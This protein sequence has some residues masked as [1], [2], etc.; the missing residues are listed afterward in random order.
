[1]PSERT[2]GLRHPDEQA[3]AFNA[4]AIQS[5]SIDLFAWI[6]CPNPMLANPSKAL[7]IRV[8]HI[9]GDAV[10]LEA[11]SSSGLSEGLRLTVRR[12][13]PST[14]GADPAIVAEIEIES[15]AETSAAGRILSS[16]Q[17]IEPGDVAFLSEEGL[18]Q[19]QSDMH[20]RQVKKY[21]QVVNFTEGTPPEQ[22]IRESIPKPP[23]P[24]VNRIRGLI[25]VDYNGLQQPE[26]GT[27]SQFGF[28]LR[29]DATRL[30]G[31]Y[32]TVSGYHRGKIQ[33]RHD[34]GRQETLTDLIN[35]TYHLSVKYDNPGSRWVAGGGRLYVPWASSLS[36][37]DGFYLGRRVGKETVGIFG[38]TTPD[39]S[40]W[41]YDPNR[42]M[43]GAFVNFE[44]GGFESFRFT[45]TS[46]IALSWSH[47]D[48]DRQFG[49]FENGIFYKQYVSVYSTV[50]ADLLTDSNGS[51]KRELTLSRNYLTIRVQPHKVISFDI[52]ESYFRN[53]PTFDPQLIGTGLL[54]KFLFQG[55]SGGFRLTLPYRLEF[56]ANTGRSSRTNDQK[57]SWNYLA[58]AAASNILNSGVRAEY[59]YSR[60]DSSFGRGTYQ[61]VLAA[62]EIGEG[63]RFQV[64]AGRQAMESTFTA[65]NRAHF[66]N[67][68]MDWYF[69]ARYLLGFGATVYRGQTQHYNQYFINLGYRFDSRNRKKE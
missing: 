62:R 5:A 47:W 29:A 52:N 22:E 14:D 20:A 8:K 35:R 2:R 56:Y 57:P 60:F 41:N 13:K 3:K 33:S 48:P 58:G 19:V 27:R 69:G 39:P 30:G 67:G 59:R 61:S 23:L 15:V 42:L 4:G 34:P 31:T 54:D 63:F 24:E 36:T 28:V 68:N 43:T 12:G 38:G 55:L 10:Y 53:A 25:G 46:G 21:A 18:R 7:E 16:Q 26:S 37:I 11:G 40:S 17:K 49:F 66:I 65:Q 64:Q 6:I 50:E 45:S 32:W 51:G 1:V 44:R 9:Y